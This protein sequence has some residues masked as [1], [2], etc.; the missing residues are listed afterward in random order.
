[1]TPT[2]RS[3]MMPSVSPIGTLS[4][5]LDRD[6]AQPY[7]IWDQPLTVAELRRWLAHSDPATRALWTARVL[8]EARY[9]D[10]WRFVTLEQVLG[11]WPLVQRHLGRTR[12]FWEFLIEGWRD[13][14]LI[15][16]HA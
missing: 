14:G 15:P 11:L 1:M 7:F 16:R 12:K 13:D 9:T 5:D 2:R 10:V 3:G 4:L 8:R 6:E